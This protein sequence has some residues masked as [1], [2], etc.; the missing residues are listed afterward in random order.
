[1]VNKLVAENS[2]KALDQDEYLLKYEKYENKYNE[3]VSKIEEAKNEKAKKELQAKE[4]ERFIQDL[5]TRTNY[6]EEWDKE[7]WNKFIDKAIVNKNGTITFKFINGTE[8]TK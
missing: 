3:L 2:N 6:L 4:M 8:T 5:E 7:L 1:M